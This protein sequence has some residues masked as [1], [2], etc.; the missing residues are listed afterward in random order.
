MDQD[1]GLRCA[2]QEILACGLVWG[3]AIHE[4]HVS[5]RH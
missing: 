5:T 4:D 1:S 3:R 2:M